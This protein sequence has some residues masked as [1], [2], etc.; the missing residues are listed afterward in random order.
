MNTI[1]PGPIDTVLNPAEGEFAEQILPYTALNRFGH[2]EEVASLVGYLASDAAAYI[3]GT[4]LTID[5][6]TNA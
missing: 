3:T 6:G 2:P 4:S 1:Q 5:G